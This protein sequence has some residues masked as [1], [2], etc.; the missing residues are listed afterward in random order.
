MLLL[1]WGNHLVMVVSQATLRLGPPLRLLL[2][3]TKHPLRQLGYTD[4][5]A[6]GAS[7]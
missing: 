2:T 5:W 6:G 7:S 1:K 3:I 4:P